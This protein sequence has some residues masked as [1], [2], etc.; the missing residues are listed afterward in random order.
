MTTTTTSDVAECLLS[1][2]ETL[3]V[4]A[5][6]KLCLHVSFTG[7][8]S[9][10]R[11]ALLSRA[12]VRGVNCVRV[13]FDNVAVDCRTPTAAASIAASFVLRER[14]QHVRL[15]IQHEDLTVWT[16]QVHNSDE[17]SAMP[18]YERVLVHALA[19]S[20]PELVEAMV[21]ALA[22]ML[23]VVNVQTVAKR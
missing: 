15:S 14:A 16:T 8:A 1:A 18:F 17:V 3:N 6:R 10:K 19:P 9:A 2:F 20:R 23:D 11:T 7:P 12:Y 22:V 4:E 5:A 13:Q 21:Q